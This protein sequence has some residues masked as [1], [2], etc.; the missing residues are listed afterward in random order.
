MRADCHLFGSLLETFVFSELL[1]MSSRS[2]ERVSMFHN[3]DRDDFEVDFVLEN[4]AGK[5]VG[6]EVKAAA[7]ITRRD[8][9]GLDRLASAAGTTF[10]QGILLYSGNQTLAFGEKLKSVPIAALWA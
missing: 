9:G 8:F 5:V 2:D 10:V 1:K 6:I 4:T 3:R 7:S